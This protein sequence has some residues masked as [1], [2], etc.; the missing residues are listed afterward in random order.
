[1]TDNLVTPFHLEGQP[2]RGRVVR[3]G[4]VLDEILRAHQLPTPVARLLGEAVITA[5]LAGSSLKFEGRVIVQANGAGPVSFLVSDFT[6]D[7]GLRGYIRYDAEALPEQP[8]P[9]LASLMGAGQF[10]LTID[11]GKAEH[12]Y[13]G[14]AALE[15]SSFAATAEAYFRQSEQLPSQLVVAIAQITD[16]TG[17]TSWRG[18]GLLAQRIASDETDKTDAWTTAKAMIATIA[19]DELTDPMLGTETLLFRLFHQQ[20]VRMFDPLALYKRCTCTKTRLRQVLANFSRG[21]RNEMLSDAGQIEMTC[22]YC[23]KTF[24]FTPDELEPS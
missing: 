10:A 22:E 8:Q 9:D 12:R 23:A 5:A 1:M 13:Q 21:E 18:G 11:P 15:T 20:G 7:G 14:I 19:D 17:Q 6:T 2:V 16:Q 4:T 3:L 24:G